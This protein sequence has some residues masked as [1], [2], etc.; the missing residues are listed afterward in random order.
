MKALGH[1]VSCVEKGTRVSSSGSYSVF[2]VLFSLGHT[3]HLILS[4]SYY[5]YVQNKDNCI[6]QQGKRKH[7]INF[8]GWNV[9][10]KLKN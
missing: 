8:W 6:C 3:V 5:F 2:V 7:A 9:F 1:A 10:A 4:M